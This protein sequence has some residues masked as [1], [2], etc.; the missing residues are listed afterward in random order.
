LSRQRSRTEE[1]RGQSDNLP[2][3]PLTSDHTNARQP[4]LDVQGQVLNARPAD[5]SPGLSR[6]AKDGVD[7]KN[8]EHD[9]DADEGGERGADKPETEGI[10]GTGDEEVVA[11]EVERSGDDEGNDGSVHETCEGR[12]E[13]EESEERVRG[14][15]HLAPATNDGSPQI[16]HTPEEK[17]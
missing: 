11:K 9:V 5:P 3:P 8:D 13:W 2:A 17:E 6:C 10:D 14:R 1:T 12:D 15:T 4:K 16:Q 7:E